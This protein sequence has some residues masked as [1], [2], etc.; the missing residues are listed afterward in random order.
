MKFVRD[1]ESLQTSLADLRIVDDQTI[2][3]IDATTVVKDEEA[4]EASRDPGAHGMGVLP[5]GGERTEHEESE[6]PVLVPRPPSGRP[7]ADSR[8]RKHSRKYSREMRVGGGPSENVFES[9]VQ[10]P[11]PAIPQH[12]GDSSD[13]ECDFDA[14]GLNSSWPQE[15]LASRM[16]GP[17]RKLSGYC[18]EAGLHD[19][20]HFHEDAGDCLQPSAA[21]PKSSGHSL[22]RL[23]VN[24][25]GMVA[26]ARIS[27]ASD[28]DRISCKIG[29]LIRPGSSDA[30]SSQS[31]KRKTFFN[32]GLEPTL[33]FDGPLELEPVH[34]AEIPVFRSPSASS[35]ARSYSLMQLPPIGKEAPTH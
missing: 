22:K 10:H 27:S 12:A 4:A 18:P 24:A 11:R 15:A 21:R 25:G 31:P 3:L 8:G 35:N 30:L 1:Q 5:Q 17:I 34:P 28:S 32:F 7:R 26:A 23:P 29:T 6:E 20:K 16:F 9:R 13:G 14:H 19:V 2:D 33:S